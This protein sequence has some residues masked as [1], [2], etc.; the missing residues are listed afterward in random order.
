MKT[1]AAVLILSAC[2]LAASPARAGLAD[3]RAAADGDVNA[4]LR[5]GVQRDTEAIPMLRDF[6]ESRPDSDNM[7]HAARLALAKLGDG[8]WEKA[9]IKGLAKKK[10]LASRL[11][12]IRALGYVGDR[13]TV[14]HLIP[15][16]S[17]TGEVSN[18][19]VEALGDILPSVQTRLLL[20]EPNNPNR[21][22]QW[23]RWWNDS[24]LLPPQAWE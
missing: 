7:G 15:L 21:A 17:E 8:G 11:R 24:R 19:A 5:L 2:A 23:Q 3:R 22:G 20:S 18:T 9:L 14:K 1:L 4:A 10:P 6:A 12:A 16:L 13:E